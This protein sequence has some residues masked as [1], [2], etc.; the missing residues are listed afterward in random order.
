MLHALFLVKS[1]FQVLIQEAKN[2]WLFSFHPPPL[3]PLRRPELLFS[4]HNTSPALG[5]EETEPF[6]AWAPGL[7]PAYAGVRMPAEVSAPGP[8][9]ERVSA[10]MCMSCP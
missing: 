10:N 2:K 7:A 1:K 3:H 5:E 9:T 8:Q 6:R 4:L